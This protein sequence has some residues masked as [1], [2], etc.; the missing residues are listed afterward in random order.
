MLL[1]CVGPFQFNKSSRPSS[2]EPDR[3]LPV[4]PEWGGAACTSRSSPA[5][6]G[7]LLV[8]ACAQPGP[9]EAALRQ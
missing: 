8:Q 2:R 4:P 3:S 7:V 1:P 5:R 6:A 9:R